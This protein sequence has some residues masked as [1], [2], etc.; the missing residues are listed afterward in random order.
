MAIAGAVRAAAG[1]HVSQPPMPRPSER[2]RPAALCAELVRPI[3][4]L[5]GLC[6]GGVGDAVCMSVGGLGRAPLAAHVLSA[7]VAVLVIRNDPA[8][9]IVA[10]GRIDAPLTQPRTRWSGDLR[11]TAPRATM[12]A[13]TE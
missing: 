4:C 3:F 5:S 6:S 2:P 11:G 13:R 10:E 7:A 9:A 1:A 8:V 12:E